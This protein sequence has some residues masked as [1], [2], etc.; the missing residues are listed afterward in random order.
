LI[1]PFGIKGRDVDSE[2][3][4]NLKSHVLIGGSS[5]VGKTTVAI[6]LSNYF[7]ISCIHLDQ[8]LYTI[9]DPG[10][11]FLSNEND[12]WRFSSHELC[13]RLIQAGANASPYIDRLLQEL[14]HK[15]TA[16]IIEGERIH[17]SVMENAIKAKKAVGIFIIEENP[18]QLYQTLQH[19]SNRFSKLTEEKK[20]MVINMD[21][22]FGQW[23]H[24]EAEARCLPWLYSQ[25]W[26]TLGNR[27]IDLIMK[28][29][30]L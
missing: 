21:C 27:V 1:N 8:Y 13:N 6:D 9:Q 30:A 4:S 10:L 23:L 2:S 25:P 24:M 19:R 3:C 5:S 11:A 22:Y 7:Q 28:Q 12:M 14:Q 16:Q 15:E 26:S 18:N 20:W 17:P 29:I